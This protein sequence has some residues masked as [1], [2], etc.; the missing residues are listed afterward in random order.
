M[1]DLETAGPT[2]Y[3]R[4]RWTGLVALLR[5]VGHVLAKIDSKQSTVH[6]G[7]IAAEW[8]LLGQDRSANPIFWEFIEEERNNVLKAFEFGAQLVTTFR[9]GTTHMA[10]DGTSTAGPSGPTTYE[11]FVRSPSF[12]GRDA[13]QTA[14]DAIDFWR[15]Y[16]NRVEA[17]LH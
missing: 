15:A 8:D 4:S 10:R 17:R 3:W 5:A 13:I 6:K 14:R 9:P 16:L 2:P 11:A 12:G 7:A 1:E